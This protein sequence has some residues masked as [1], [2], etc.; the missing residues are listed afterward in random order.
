MISR[1]INSDEFKNAI[2][3]GFDG[4]NGI[5]PLYCPN[6]K[7]KCLDDIVSD[8]HKRINCG[9]G[10]V[11]IKGVYD[12]SQLIGYYAYEGKTLVSFAM[13]IKFRKRKYLHELWDLIRRDLK[14]KFQAFMWTRNQRGIKWLQK[15]KM[16]IVV[17]DNLLT[18]LIY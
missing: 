15:N 4:D 3:E 8:I 14:G 10:D 12:K 6:V 1:N 9:A 7:V 17:A 5:Y 13:N 11:V 18:H 16:E 2:R